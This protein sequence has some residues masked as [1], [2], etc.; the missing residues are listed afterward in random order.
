MR[1]RPN[2]EVRKELE[3]RN[4]AQ[5]I[6]K[7]PSE[8]LSRILVLCVYI[9][10]SNKDELYSEFACQT[11][12]SSVCRHWRTV[13]IETASLWSLVTLSDFP[14]HP[15]FALHLSR[16]GSTIPLYINIEMTDIFWDETEE[17]TMEECAQRVRDT[18]TFIVSH[19]GVTPRWRTVSIRT[20]LFYAHRAVIRFLGSSEMPELLSLELLFDGPNDND[21]EDGRAYQDTQLY[22]PSLLLPIPPPRLDTIKLQGVPNAFLFGHPTQPQFSSLVHLE[23]ELVL[24]YPNLHDLN[25]LLAANPQLAAFCLKMGSANEFLQH[26]AIRNLPRVNLPHLKE[27]TLLHIS[28]SRWVLDLL[29]MLDAPNVD[30]LRL[31]F[32][33]SDEEHRQLLQYIANGDNR[34][35]GPLFP[36]LT[37][38]MFGYDLDEDLV[39]DLRLLLT[40]YTKI[41]FL[42]ISWIPIEV[43]LEHPW[44][45][46]EL[47]HLRVAGAPGELLLKIVDA[48]H[49]AGSPL[50]VIE[51][52]WRFRNRVKPHELEYL[53]DKV[54][55][56]FIDST[57]GRRMDLVD[58]IQGGVGA[59]DE[60]GDWTDEDSGEFFDGLV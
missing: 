60:G 32:I 49:S 13:A 58:R 7:L 48:R 20:D 47:L 29:V 17:G 50:K 45:V 27:L 21:E 18:L 30:Y 46:P 11:T 31:T 26:P 34:T 5:S 44:L 56:A 35:S 3:R 59:E 2:E 8:L 36:S 10:D 39:A 28:T 24:S 52:D 51:A 42:D 25:L 22:E 4:S 9:C 33:D 53:R 38:L 14:P 1:L 40:A 6:N 16:A 43:L 19:G 37:R 55:F 12:L 23:L 15:R 57:Y 41:T 54:D